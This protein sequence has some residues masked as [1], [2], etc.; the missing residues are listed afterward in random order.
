MRNTRCGSGSWLKMFSCGSAAASRWVLLYPASEDG[1][2]LG[3]YTYRLSLC[4]TWMRWSPIDSLASQRIYCTSRGQAPY[5]AECLLGLFI[6]KLAMLC[7]LKTL[8]WATI[9]FVSRPLDPRVTHITRL[10]IMAL[11]FAEGIALVKAHVI[12]SI[13]VAVIISFVSQTFWAWSRL[14]HVPGPTSASLWK[15]WMLRHTLSGRMNLELKKVCDQY[16]ELYETFR[17]ICIVYALISIH[18]L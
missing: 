2:S 6:T 11:L 8:L 16:G 14:R 3:W 17:F 9:F 18:V 12:L 15:G 10:P 13:F 1:P 5:F 7:L 4:P